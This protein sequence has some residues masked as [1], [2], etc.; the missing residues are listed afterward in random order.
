MPSKFAEQLAK[1]EGNLSGG[2]E[3]WVTAADD[4]K[5]LNTVEGVANK[6]TLVDENGALRLQGN[7][8]VEFQVKD[9][10]GI[11]SP[12]NRANAGFVNGG[13]TGGGAREWLFPSDIQIYNVKIRYLGK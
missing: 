5:G 6:L 12:Y 13:K 7:A 8:V 10:S 3:A 9:V 4:L 1:G 11:A 2:S